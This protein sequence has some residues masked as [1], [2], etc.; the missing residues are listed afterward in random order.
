M[1]VLPVYVQKGK[2]DACEIDPK[3]HPNMS[4]HASWAAQILMWMMSADIW[5]G[6]GLPQALEWGDD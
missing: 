2:Q 6:L 1:F 5:Q 3:G 4:L